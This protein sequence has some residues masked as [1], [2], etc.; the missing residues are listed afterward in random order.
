MAEIKDL[1][2]IEQSAYRDTIRDGLTEILGGFL[3][4]LAPIMFYE[5]TFII[6]FAV[7]YVIFLPV[8]VE[9]ARKKYTYPRIGYVKVR[10]S[11]SGI[12][13]KGLVGLT[14]VV[15]LG[16]FAATFLLTNDIYNYLNW[17]TI[18]PFTIG[19]IMLGPSEYLVNKSGMKKYWLLGIVTSIL[20]LLVSY[21]SIAN[22]GPN[23]YEGV[24]TFSMIL[25]VGLLIIGTITFV[26][27]IRNNPVIAAQEDADDEQW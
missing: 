5:P 7:F 10:I 3:F 24:A 14:I 23:P 21:L 16:T 19:M 27:F 1:K 12:N 17:V 22:P 13:L 6:Y 25:G 20:G 11:E 8:I 15:I 26:R 4:A 18:L 9:G 2:D